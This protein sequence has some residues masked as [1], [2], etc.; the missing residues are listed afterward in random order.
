LS[1]F[2]ALMTFAKEQPG[3]VNDLTD[4]PKATPMDIWKSDD[5]KAAGDAIKA[6]HERLLRQDAN[7]TIEELE[8]EGEDDQ[9]NFE[10]AND[11]AFSKAFY[12]LLKFFTFHACLSP[13]RKTLEDSTN[14]SS[15]NKE[16]Q[17]EPLVI[18]DEFLEEYR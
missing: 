5:W 6:L 16:T 1:E 4:I 2:L 10:T 7:S 18:S 9:Q 3:D 15:G 8:K 12:K 11:S 14:E 17:F 13:F